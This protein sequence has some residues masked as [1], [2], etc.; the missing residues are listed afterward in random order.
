MRQVASTSTPPRGADGQP[1]RPGQLVAG[2]DAGGEHDQVGVDR[3]AV[4]EYQPGAPRRPG[5]ARSRVVATPEVDGDAQVL[6]VAA[7]HRAAGLVDLHRHQPGRELD[8]V[9]VPARAGAARSPPPGRAGRR[10]SPRRSA[11]PCG[12][13]PDRRQVVE[14][15][16]D[17]DTRAG[18]VPATGG[19][20]AYEPVASTS[21]SYA[22]LA[23]RRGHHLRGPVDADGRLAEPQLAPRRPGCAGSAPRRRPRRR[24]PRAAPGRTPGARSSASTVTRQRP[25]RSRARSAS[26][27][28][29]P[30]M[31]LPTTTSSPL[32][33]R[34]HLHPSSS[35]VA[36]QSTMPLDR[37]PAAAA[38]G[39]GPGRAH[40]RS[41]DRPGA[42]APAAHQRALA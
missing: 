4:G 19:T 25:S 29:C 7:E 3:A 8:H 6:D 38:A 27:N 39:A 10:R 28:R 5:R 22:V 14:G 11:R 15:P 36:S 2:P 9:R 20:N 13:R 18:R 12:V 24:T 32:A 16:V 37:V 35:A 30:T 26:T 1:G 41:V 17:E 42:G 31:P 40:R 23:G 33:H 34:R 21:A